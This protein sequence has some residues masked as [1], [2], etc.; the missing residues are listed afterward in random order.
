MFEQL[1]QRFGGDPKYKRG[2]SDIV[3]L[4]TAD[5]A[6]MNLSWNSR[7]NSATLHNQLLLYPGLSMRALGSPEYIIGDLWRK[8]EG[9]GHITELWARTHRKELLESLEAACRQRKLQAI[10][11][12]NDEHAENPRFYFDAGYGVLENIIYYDKPD[13]II[14]ESFQGM[15][16]FTISY[17]QMLEEDLLIVDHVTF[18]WL[19]WNSRAEMRFYAR[20]PDVTIQ[21][22]CRSKD[23]KPV[24]YFSFTMYERWGHLDRLAVTPEFQG[25]GYGA[26]QLSAAIKMMEAKGARRVTLSTQLTN[27][28]SQRLYERFGFKKV[29]NL[30]YNLIGR[31]LN[32]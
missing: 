32:Q 6:N 1:R 21:I 31:W 10:V 3:E 24:G 17:N 26:Y 13:T 23:N 2:S 11:V 20:Q 28:Q 27:Y 22:C 30:E 5:A 14:Y 19:W 9:V 18:P 25:M 7:F 29:Q 12:S 15:P 8:H 4:T 16:L